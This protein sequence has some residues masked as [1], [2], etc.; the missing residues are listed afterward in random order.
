MSQEASSR[1]MAAG[2]AAL[3]VTLRYNVGT[4]ASRGAANGAVYE[5]VTTGAVEAYAGLA[6]ELVGLVD[7]L[8]GSHG[9]LDFRVRIR[10]VAPG[11]EGGPVGYCVGVA[12]RVHVGGVEPEYEVGDG[13][14]VQ[15]GVGGHEGLRGR[16]YVAAA[17]G[18]LG[19]EVVSGPLGQSRQVV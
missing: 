1:I 2:I 17:V 19:R 8:L 5:E 14:L 13:V 10:L 7:G 18:H 6:S 9:L 15:Q 4:H 12:V 16:P 11:C 3:G